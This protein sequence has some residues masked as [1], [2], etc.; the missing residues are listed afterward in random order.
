MKRVGLSVLFVLALCMFAETGGVIRGAAYGANQPA[1]DSSD[2]TSMEKVLD[3]YSRIHGDLVSNHLGD[4]KQ[5]ASFLLVATRKVKEEKLRSDLEK[6][7]RRMVANSSSGMGHPSI[8]DAR[9][10]FKSLSIP[11]TEWVKKYKP[12]GW[13]VIHC[14]MLDASWVQKKGEE[15]RNP[16]STEE[17]MRSCGEKVLKKE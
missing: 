8:P 13:T 5:H 16:Y 7:T 14:S 10:D 12:E 2:R 9:N 1:N 6:I 17:N 11:V 4:I 15:I 3:L